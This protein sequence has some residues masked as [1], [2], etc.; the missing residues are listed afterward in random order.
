MLFFK[1]V[2]SAEL[3]P[4]QAGS[5]FKNVIPAEAGIQD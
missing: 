5:I 2:I 3:V 1:N 4:A